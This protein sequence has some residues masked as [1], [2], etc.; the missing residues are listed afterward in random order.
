VPTLLKI[1]DDFKND[2]PYV[3][4][5]VSKGVTIWFLC[6][7]LNENAMDVDVDWI[8]HDLKY[9]ALGLAAGTWINDFN[10]RCYTVEGEGIQLYL[11][12]SGELSLDVDMH[13]TL[14]NRLMQKYKQQWINEQEEVDEDDVVGSSDALP[15]IWGAGDSVNHLFTAMD[16]T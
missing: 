5:A 6:L 11:S 13:V 3:R 8:P 9:S 7:S 2:T 12:A 4:I 16:F 10:F 15:Y 14:N 1:H